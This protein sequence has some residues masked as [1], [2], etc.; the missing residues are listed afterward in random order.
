MGGI[1]LA[2]GIKKHPH[3]LYV[4]VCE[5]DLGCNLPMLS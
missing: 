3:L 1:P 5:S 4:G 2:L